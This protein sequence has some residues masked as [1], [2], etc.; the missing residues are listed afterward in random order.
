M[1]HVCNGMKYEVSSFMAYTKSLTLD[2]SGIEALGVPIEKNNLLSFSG[3]QIQ[4][5]T[6]LHDQ[7][8]HL[9]IGN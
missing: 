1:C 2:L 7:V 8:I 4:T 9:S 5:Q 3:R 6:H